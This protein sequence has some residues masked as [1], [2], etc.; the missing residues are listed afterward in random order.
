MICYLVVVVVRFVVVL[1][2]LNEK[3]YTLDC[4]IVVTKQYEKSNTIY[5]F[6]K[7]TLFKI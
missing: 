6:V 4:E 1:K 5:K 7:L 2:E 3:N